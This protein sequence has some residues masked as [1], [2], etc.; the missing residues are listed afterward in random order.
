MVLRGGHPFRVLAAPVSVA[1]TVWAIEI[2]VPMGEFYEALNGVAWTM[3]LALPLVLLV[4]SAG[5]YW[6]SKRALKPV[7]RITRTAQAISAENLAARLPLRGADDELDRLSSTLNDMFAR[8]DAAFRRVTQFTAD[9]SHEL[10]TPVAI[11]RTTAELTRR[12]P[13]TDAEYTDALDQILAESER[14]SRL[15]DDLLLLARSDAEGEEFALEPM[16]LAQSLRE[17]RASRVGFSPTRQACLSQ[18]PS[19]RLARP[20]AILRRSD[21]CF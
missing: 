16:D 13:R 18:P 1:D 15:I 11:I 19:G 4:A 3:V 6:M 7:D 9:A 20:S 14:T 2:G 17:A 10:R 21:V 5:G 12:R 8:L